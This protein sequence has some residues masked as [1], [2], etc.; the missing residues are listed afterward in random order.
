M[1]HKVKT[2][3]FIS[4]R[5]K[6]LSEKNNY[7]VHIDKKINQ[8][9]FQKQIAYYLLNQL[10]KKVNNNRYAL[11]FDTIEQ[12]SDINILNFIILLLTKS[13][14]SGDDIS[15]DIIEEKIKKEAEIDKFIFG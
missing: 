11:L 5:K 7:R 1:C 3:R 9:T 14:C 8:L 2:G 13:F 12:A 6:I 4:N 10:N 15:I